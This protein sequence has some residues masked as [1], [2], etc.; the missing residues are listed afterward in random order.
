MS[1]RGSLGVRVERTDGVQR[2]DLVCRVVGLS[3]DFAVKRGDLFMVGEDCCDMDGCLDLFRAID[4]G[5]L[6]VHTHNAEGYDTTY[7]R[8]PGGEWHATTVRV[9]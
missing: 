2:E 8:H 5:C 1:K 7:W 4:E 6:A 3:Y 9:Q